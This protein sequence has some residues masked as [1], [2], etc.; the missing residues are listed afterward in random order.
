MSKESGCI[1]NLKNG[2]SY[3]VDE[4]VDVVATLLNIENLSTTEVDKRNFIVFN[5]AYDAMGS[6]CKKI[7]IRKTEI[8]DLKSFD[9]Y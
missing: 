9:T 2:E 3:R 6:V 7:F 5:D 8:S 1:I 4:N